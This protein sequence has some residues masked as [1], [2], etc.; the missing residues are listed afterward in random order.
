MLLK[1]TKMHGLGNDFVVIDAINQELSLTTNQ[2]REIADRKFGVGCDQLLLVEKPRSPGVD[3]RYRIFN[4]DGSEVEQCGNGARCF[5]RFVEEKGLTEKHEIPV[6]TKNGNI[7][8]R[9]QN[10]GDVTVNMGAPNLAPESLPFTAEKQQT[11]YEIEVEGETLEIAAVS[12]GNPHAVTLVNDTSS[13]PVLW[14][15]P[16]IEKH[17]L[18][19]N[20]VNAGFMQVV[21]RGNINLR[22]FERGCGETL[23]CGTGACAAVVAGII[24]GLLDSTVKVTLP[25]GSLVINWEG[26]NSPVMMTGPAT[27]VF[28]GEMEI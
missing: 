6:E 8:L 5:A 7:I 15:G 18:F 24:Q 4:A 23:A 1:F 13:A 17:E 11:T 16:Q 19:P 26:G 20:R 3:F 28:E 21:D 12:M 2:I 14:L 25:G 9:L 27:V 22:V 10:D